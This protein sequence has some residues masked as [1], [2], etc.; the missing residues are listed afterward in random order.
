MTD[1]TKKPKLAEQIETIVEATPSAD[2]LDPDL[3]G[4][5]DTFLADFNAMETLPEFDLLTPESAKQAVAMLDAKKAEL[6]AKLKIAQSL[7]RLLKN[8]R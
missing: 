5:L 6:A 1:E 3:S 2:T 8:P 7:T 4:Y